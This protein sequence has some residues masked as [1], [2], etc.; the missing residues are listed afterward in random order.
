MTTDE[1][2]DRLIERTD[3][4][5]QSVELLTSLHVDNERRMAE[6]MAQTSATMEK[7]TAN[8]DKLTAHVEKLSAHMEELTAKVDVV[9]ERTIQAMDAINRLAVIAAAHEQ[10]LDDLEHR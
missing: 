5:A 9:T 2:L 10:R 1:R 4:I 6:Y 8:M 3:A 7:M